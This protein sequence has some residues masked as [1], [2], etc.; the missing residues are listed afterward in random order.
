MF[1]AQILVKRPITYFMKIH[2]V[3]LEWLHADVYIETVC[4]MQKILLKAKNLRAQS[5][6]KCYCF[7][8]NTR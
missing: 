3:Y 7:Q 5:I 2:L 4:T 6:L 1:H 8:T